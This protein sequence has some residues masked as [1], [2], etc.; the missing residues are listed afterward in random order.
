MDC[1]GEDPY[2]VA[3]LAVAQTRAIQREGVAATA[4]HFAV[5][6]E[7][8]GGRDGV[9][10]SDPHLAFREMEQLH[11]YPWARLVREADPLGVMASYNDYDGV[12]V[13]G[14]H[15]FL[16]DRLR[17]AYGVRGYVV[18]DSGAVEN[19]RNKPRVAATAE[20][21]A[22]MYVAEGGNVRTMFDSPAKFIL[23]LRAAVAANHTP[24]AAALARRAAA[25]SI[26]LL[27]NRDAALPLDKAKV[28]QVLVCGPTAELPDTC[29]SR[30]G[31]HGGHVV[32]LLEGVRSAVA[33]GTDVAFRPGCTVTDRRW[34]YSEL[35][36][37]PPAG[38]DAAMI[39]DAV[40]AAASA[41]VVVLGLGDGPETIGESKSRTSLDLPGYQT[42]LAKALVHTGKP[43]VAVL[44]TGR[45]ASANWVDA[46]CAAVLQAGFPGEAGGAAVADV[47]F[48][49][50][51]PGGKLTVTVPRTVGQLPFNFPY[52]PASQDPGSAED[53]KNGTSG[54]LI[55]RPLYPFGY[56]LSYTTFA[57]ADLSVTPPIILPDGTV[58]VSATVT[59]TGRRAGDEVVQLYLRQAVASVTTY[60]MVLRGFDRVTLTPGESKRV[61]F[62]VPARAMEII[63]R[64]GRR[65][66]E[67]GRFDVM[68]AAS[69]ADVRLRGSYQVAPA[70]GR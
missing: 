60:D 32:T 35:D 49:A 25:E 67:P 12:P 62:A 58:T 51:N 40:A 68:V 6:G 52:K 11:L 48:G 2:V 18:S 31:S 55:D 34:P 15:E 21:A 43:V 26:V 45:A 24:E 19:L 50:V 56:G 61:T 28:R 5:H 37:E 9:N 8:K 46:H 13:A 20:A 39:A 4:K 30:Y 23:P 38:A 16:I 47:L 70:A 41:D 44:M 64:D 22:A 7:P 33:D 53:A 1:F 66:V 14:S 57:Y 59:N 42:D 54:P 29:L 27:R 65:T 17:T 69:S 36:Y 63:A 3:E 10:R